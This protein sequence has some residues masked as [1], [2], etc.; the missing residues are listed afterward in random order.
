MSPKSPMNYKLILL[1]SAFLV[2]VV[3]AVIVN[4]LYGIDIVYTHLFYIPII[5]TGIWYPRFAVFVAAALGLI[6]IACDYA[7]AETFKIGAW[8]RA[9][10]FIAVAYV[11]GSLARRRDSLLHSLEESENRFATAFRLSPAPLMISSIEE[12]R[13]LDVNERGLTMLGYN[14]EEMAGRSSGELSLFKDHEIGNTLAE[15]MRRQGSLRDELVQLRTKRGEI[16]EVLWS[17][18][19]IK[20]HDRSVIL[21]LLYD[22]TER[23][24]AENERARL[25]SKL[26]KAI[27]EINVLSGL[28]P[29][30]ASCKKIRDDKGYWNRI[31]SYI[32]EH[33]A[34]EFSHGIC[35]ECTEKLYPDFYAKHYKKR[36][37]GDP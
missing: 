3:L 29:I 30:C 18:E 20:Q 34:A 12:G 1:F 26:Q 8:L 9:L 15:K 27:S 33:S 31:E 17:A 2:C 35:P 4:L 28:I 13:F 10:L 11:T 16:R 36:H 32:E 5:L 37:E 22:V 21:S 14:R 6:H 23:Q 24:Q 25:L 7:T 19:T